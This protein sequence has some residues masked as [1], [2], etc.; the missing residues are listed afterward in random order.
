MCVCVRLS[1]MNWFLYFACI[2]CVSVCLSYVCM[3]VC[4]CKFINHMVCVCVRIYVC[5]YVRVC[6]CGV[7]VCVWC[8]TQPK[9]KPLV[10]WPVPIIKRVWPKQ[11]PPYLTQWWKHNADTD[12]RINTGPV[13]SMLSHYCMPIE[14]FG[15]VVCSSLGL[16]HICCRMIS[17]KMKKL[18]A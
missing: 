12:N 1:V 13:R 11:C 2:V 5:M 16:L 10:K 6:V 18:T 3:C 9:R 17:I 14:R 8:S 7:C 15:L 4:V